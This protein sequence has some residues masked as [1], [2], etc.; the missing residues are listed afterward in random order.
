MLGVAGQVDTESNDSLLATFNWGVTDAT[1]L[2]FTAG[3]SS[4]PDDRASVD[5]DM[6]VA[7]VDHKFG[8]VGV[9]LAIEQWGDEDALETSDWRGTVYYGPERYRIGLAYEHR[10]IDIPFTIVGTARRKARAAPR[11]C[12]AMASAIDVR[13]QPAPG[14]QLYFGATEYD[15]DRDLA[16]LPRIA[17]LN[18][19]SA[20]T[21][22]LANS[23]LDHERLIGF[24]R[25]IGAKLLTVTYT[26][27][28]SAIDGA[29]F[30]TF[31]AA[32][33]FPIGKRVDLEVNLGHGR[34][35]LAEA[36][37]YGGVLLLV[38]GR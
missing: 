19:L 14:W 33:L 7:S 36:G 10:D 22:T 9:A 32:L 28:R 26:T 8:R 6:L 11:S 4:S 13:V 5:A 15:Y 27:D 24:D 31:D 30:E 34:S 29:E 16:P 20:S 23:F 2:S 17:Q 37:I 25:A 38:Y 21:L 1:W 18:L 3:R 35:E 12:R